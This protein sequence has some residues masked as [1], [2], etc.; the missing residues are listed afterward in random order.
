MEAQ[1][2]PCKVPHLVN[3][4]KVISKG[5]VVGKTGF[6]LPRLLYAAYHYGMRVLRHHP[7]SSVTDA[8]H[9]VYSSS[10]RRKARC[11]VECLGRVFH[12]R[13]CA[14]RR[15]VR[16]TR[17]TLGAECRN[18]GDGVSFWRVFPLTH[19]YPMVSRGGEFR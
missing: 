15:Q 1:K 9:V 8:S 17:M 7:F 12:G 2:N 6:Y 19:L 13:P 3:P 4:G 5:E 14:G 11:S 18:A 10:S 16:A